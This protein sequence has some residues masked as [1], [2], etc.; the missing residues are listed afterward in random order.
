MGIDGTLLT[1]LENFLG[2]RKHCVAVNGERSNWAWVR[3]GV[4]QGTVLGPVLFTIF[5]NDLPELLESEIKI[6]ADDTKLYNVG[7]SIGI[8]SLKEDLK[9]IEL[10]S[11][12]W[13]IKPN[14]Q[15]CAVMHMG[16]NNPRVEYEL[17]KIQL[18]PTK[19]EKDLGVIIQSDLKINKQINE[20]VKKANSSLRRIKQNFNY[21]DA[22]SLTILYKTYVRP[23]L[24]YCVQAWSPFLQKDIIKLE[25]VQK[26]ATKMVP[27]LR[28]LPYERRLS[29][30]GLTT[31]KERRNRGDMIEVFKILNNIDYISD[32][33]NFF[34]QNYNN[35]RGHCNKLY[36]R[37]CNTNLRKNFFN[38][39]IVNKWNS[40]PSQVVEASSVN[41]FKNRLDKL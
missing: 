37:G 40:L 8:K 36:K 21:L 11:D 15:K 14:P 13:L 29:V 12:E 20:C 16:K 31:L 17:N 35:T 7:N 10:W 1:W 25:N 18:K 19:N 4:P 34:P 39:R 6:F 28:T 27:F 30:L 9:L 24:E 23:H 33:E 22:T 5:I 2:G 41:S 38:Q 32:K 26:K 3:S